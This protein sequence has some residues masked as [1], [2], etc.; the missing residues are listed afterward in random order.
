MRLFTITKLGLLCLISTSI[1]AADYPPNID[2]GSTGD[3]L[4]HRAN[5]HGRM[6]MLSTA[7]PILI[8]NPILPGSSN[9]GI[10]PEVTDTSWDLSDLTNPTLIQ[11]QNC[12]EP[13]GNCYIGG[14]VHFHAQITS[15]ANG[16]AYLASGRWWEFGTGGWLTY[17]ANAET[18]IDQMY[19][20]RDPLAPRSLRGTE[21]GEPWR[22][23][24][25]TSP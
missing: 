3:F 10:N 9:I 2:Y 20:H 6:S 24:H 13:S 17:D 11:K 8:A 12:Y 22:Y 14:G 1:L 18:S 21:L 15:Y 4:A 7:G 16:K 19:Y 25:L 5:Q 23:S